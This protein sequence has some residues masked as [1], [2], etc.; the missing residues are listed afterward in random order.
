MQTKIILYTVE[1]YFKTTRHMFGCGGIQKITRRARPGPWTLSLTYSI[2]FKKK[3]ENKELLILSLTVVYTLKT[4]LQLKCGNLC[5]DYWVWMM[6][7]LL[8]L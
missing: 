7:V 1:V 5:D 2:C 6:D 8:L 4:E 3:K